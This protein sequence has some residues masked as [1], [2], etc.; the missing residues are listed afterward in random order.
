VRHY[1]HLFWGVPCCE[2]LSALDLHHLLS[3]S[4]FLT[5]A[6]SL[7]QADRLIVVGHV[8]R[9]QAPLLQYLWG[10]MAY[11][12]VSLHIAGCQ[13]ALRSYSLV[14]NLEEVI[15]PDV[16]ID[17]CVLER[18]DLEDALARKV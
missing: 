6:Q 17:S 12:A 15:T 18:K 4:S 14:V 3:N 9:K 7:V 10:Q 5:K 16:V 11:P 8:T 1:Y 13:K 2:R